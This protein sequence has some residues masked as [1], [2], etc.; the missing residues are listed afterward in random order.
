M[1][2]SNRRRDILT[3]IQRRCKRRMEWTE[4]KQP[5]QY[6]CLSPFPLCHLPSMGSLI[7]EAFCITLALVW[8]CF[9]QA[10]QHTYPET[11]IW[12][13]TSLRLLHLSS[14]NNFRHNWSLP[15]PPQQTPHTELPRSQPAGLPSWNAWQETLGGR[16]PW[17]TVILWVRNPGDISAL[18]GLP[19]NTKSRDAECSLREEYL[20]S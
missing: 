20:K 2:Q 15:S 5:I 1:F 12:Y 16:R 19:R 18:K 4:W 3:A 13:L 11:H 14:N 10:V 7:S 6:D 8:V 9:S 17:L